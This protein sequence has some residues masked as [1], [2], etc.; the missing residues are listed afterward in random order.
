MHICV[1]KAQQQQSI[2][3]SNEIQTNI[4]Y[5]TNSNTISIKNI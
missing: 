1:L 2:D 3:L 4:V 5:K